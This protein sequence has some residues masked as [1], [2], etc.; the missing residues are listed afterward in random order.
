MYMSSTTPK[1]KADALA[2]VQALIAGTQKHFPNG[3]FT[4]GNV[5][6]TT[7]SLIQVFQSLATAMTGQN[8]AQADAK[9]AV[10]ATRGLRAK[11]GPIIQAYKSYV[12]TTFAGAT[13]TLADFGI[14]APKARTPMT[15]E[16]L[17]AKKAKA[18]ATRAARGTT[19]KKQKLAVK[20]NVTGVNV[21]PV[22]TPTAPSPVQPASAAP[23]ASSAPKS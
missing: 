18:E 11:V 6:Y 16:Q 8:A 1:T 2:F 4:L 17:A 3:Q 7:A 15:T 23:G 20:G 9:D 12:L 13:Q 14:P 19:S 22:T 5:A 21:T 10:A